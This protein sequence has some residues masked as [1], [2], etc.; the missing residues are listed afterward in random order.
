MTLSSLI[1]IKAFLILSVALS[2]ILISSW[3]IC[4]AAITIG[5]LELL[6]YSSK[7]KS[8]A[9]DDTLSPLTNLLRHTHPQTV[10]EL[11]DFG[12]WEYLPSTSEFTLSPKCRDLL[13]LDHEVIQI[14][15]PELLNVIH[16]DDVEAFRATFSNAA[17]ED[18]LF[19]E[20]RTH[21]SG[22]YNQWLRFDGHRVQFSDREAIF[23]GRLV[24]S[25]S[26]VL[27]SRIQSEMRELYTEILEHRNVTE[28]LQHICDRV[29][30]IE[31]AI[32]CIIFLSNDRNSVPMLIHEAD[33]SEEFRTIL[34][35]ITLGDQQAEYTLTTRQ[36]EPLY[37]ADLHQIKAWRSTAGLDYKEHIKTYLG[38]TLYD[39]DEK[40]KGAIAI[41]LPNDTIARRVLESIISSVHKVASIAI[42]THLEAIAKDYIQQQL[43]HSQ[44]MDTLGYLTGGI[45]HDFNNI[46]GS[47][48][49]YNNL[50]SK[51]ANKIHNEQIQSYTNEVAVAAARARDLIDQM[52]TYSRAE[53]V[54]QL[55]VEPQLIIKEVIQL[56]RSMIPASI[57]IRFTFVPDTPRIMISPISLHQIILNILINAKDSFAEHSGLV[58]IHIDSV[59]NLNGTCQSCHQQFTGNYVTIRI[60]D[61]GSGIDPGIEKNIFTPFFTT[62]ESG[63]GTGMGLSV[64]HS[65]LHDADSHISLKTAVGQGSTFTLYF[66]EYTETDHI[67]LHSSKHDHTNQDESKGQGQHIVVVDDD[68]A[69]S[70]LM[71]EILENHGYRVSR[72]VSG[73]DALKAFNQNPA[74]YDLLL[75][76]QTMPVMTGDEL[77]CEMMRQ[78]PNLPVIVCTG[79]SERLTDELA[80][81][82]GIKAIFKKPVDIRLLLDEVSGQLKQRS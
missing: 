29:S 65:L 24:E 68:I 12:L 16:Q 37:I 69:L 59:T 48:V 58:E 74:D 44:K 45:A 32:K 49:G 35:R 13:N 31:P 3:W 47:I 38:Q 28:T 78:R 23:A 1:F 63:K 14:A 26:R 81:E 75:T 61:N 15:L 72:F 19:I 53:P 34:N 2:A 67:Q 30:Q 71:E 33:L 62:K 9:R 39:S 20:T 6:D 76:D 57:D 43:Y 46:L 55:V 79:F 27:E 17:N 40:V 4:L 51:I 10:T 7:N 54:E 64:I 66:P 21:E 56:V 41:Y 82:I 50:A 5:F 60:T 8:L 80:E 22:V 52:M 18:K 11:M 36:K 73:T 77:A 70:L 25:T 42:D